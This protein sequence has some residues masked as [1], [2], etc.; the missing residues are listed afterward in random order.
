MRDSDESKNSSE[1]KSLFNV[2]PFGRVMQPHRPSSRS[3]TAYEAH[4]QMSLAQENSLAE[5]T[6]C[7]EPHIINL[8]GRSISV[9]Q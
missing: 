1:K 5:E 7:E 4:Q 9:I 2:S 8:R 6:I 3:M